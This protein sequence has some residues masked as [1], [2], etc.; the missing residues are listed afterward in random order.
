V[1]IA[2]LEYVRE[3]GSNPFKS[4][5]ESLNAPAAVK[6][7]AAIARMELGNLSSVK[8][9]SGI[10]EYRIDFGPGYRL[11][12]GKDGGNLIILL[13]GGTKQRQQKDIARAMTM[14]SECKERKAKR[15]KGTR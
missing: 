11:Y 3:D 2:V 8:W 5:F 13:G 4:W 15:T 14:W 6:V 10:G 7:T 1:A 12:L 9:F